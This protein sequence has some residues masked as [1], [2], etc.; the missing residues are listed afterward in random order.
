MFLRN[1]LFKITTASSAALLI[2][3]IVFVSFEPAELT[4]QSVNDTINV[5]LEVDTGIAISSP[6]DVDLKGPGNANMG[7]AVNTAVGSATWTV[8]TNAGTG[9]T[10]QI[11]NASTAP[12]LKNISNPADGDF[13]DYTETVPG[14]PETWSVAS[15]AYE[16]GMSVRGTDVNTGTYGTDSDCI[17]GAGVPSATLNYRHLSTTDF[18]VASRSATTTT[19]GIDTEVCFAAE[20]NGVFAAAG[21]YQAEVT[22][23]AT[24]N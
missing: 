6:A 19:S 2:V 5:N 20:Q 7:A 12:A 17:A 21:S 10:L 8:T 9:Y 16:F 13:A 14:T 11:K 18:T 22:A 15:G 24:V 4:A 3:A 1:H 23:T